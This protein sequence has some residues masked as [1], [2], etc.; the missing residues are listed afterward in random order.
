MTIRLRQPGL[1]A[2][3]RYGFVALVHAGVVRWGR[4]CAD[5]QN[6]NW[7]EDTHARACMPPGTHTTASLPSAR[8]LFVVA[9]ESETGAGQ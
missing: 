9:S 7:L 8:A 3:V 6:V 4:N 1:S 5:N 2:P